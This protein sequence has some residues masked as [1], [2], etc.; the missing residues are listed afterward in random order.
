MM[1]LWTVPY[2]PPYLV[3]F[4][5]TAS[6]SANPARRPELTSLYLCVKLVAHRYMLLPS[7]GLPRV[8][9][10][11]VCTYGEITT[12]R[13]GQRNDFIARVVHTAGLVVLS[14]VAACSSTYQARSRASAKVVAPK[15]LAAVTSD[16][17]HGHSDP[18]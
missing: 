8:P 11:I 15:G 14:L 18:S 2:V 7:P 12:C 3:D 17:S 13:E 1:S 4:V 10:R 16:I 9:N 6:S 5:P